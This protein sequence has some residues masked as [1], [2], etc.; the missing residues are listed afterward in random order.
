MRI[1]FS[2]L[3]S[4]EYGSIRRYGCTL[5]YEAS[6]SQP[7]TQARGKYNETNR[8]PGKRSTWSAGELHPECGLDAGNPCAIEHVPCTAGGLRSGDDEDDAAAIIIVITFCS[9]AVGAWR[10]RH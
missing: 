4:R 10:E 6:Y 8:E 7:A 2:D 3:S 9:A 5:W 1:V